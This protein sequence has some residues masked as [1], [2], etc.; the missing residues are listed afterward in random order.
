M[1][2]RP[3]VVFDCSIFWRALFYSGGSGKDCV[4]LI[5]E[6][7]VTNFISHEILDE[8]T[9][10]LTRRETLEKFS[11]ITKADALTFIEGVVFR[12]V[13]L[14]HVPRA[15]RLPRD[16]KDE[17]YL[18]LAAAADIKYLV[19][20]DRDMLDLMTG[21]DIESKQFRQRF[22]H[23]KIVKPLDLLELLRT[24]GLPLKP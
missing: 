1:N 17:P 20:T 12:S 14:S 15:F 24:P 6:G 3:R 2:H 8:V 18:D 21:I 23:L 11:F 16:P 13:L 9:D 10:V 19:T 7:S 4:N 5:K 22:R